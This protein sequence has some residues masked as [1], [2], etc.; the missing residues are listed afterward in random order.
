M[1]CPYCTEV[2]TSVKRT[3]RP[4]NEGLEHGDVKQRLR[5][6]RSCSRYFNTYEVHESQ[7]RTLDRVPDTRRLARQPLLVEGTRS[8]V[9]SSTGSREKLVERH[10]GLTND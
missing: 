3:V 7:F 2:T 4:V 8:K 1:R 6:C 5:Q 9:T 10:R